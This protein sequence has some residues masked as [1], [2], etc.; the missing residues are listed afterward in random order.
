MNELFERNE[1]QRE[2]DRAKDESKA[3]CVTTAV[4]CDICR[5]ELADG[6]AYHELTV[7]MNDA[8]YYV[9]GRVGDESAVEDTSDLTVCSRCEPDVSAAVD[10]LLATLWGL[11]AKD[12]AVGETEDEEPTVRMAAELARSGLPWRPSAGCQRRRRNEVKRDRGP[13]MRAHCPGPISARHSLVHHRGHDG[14]SRPRGR[15]L[16]RGRAQPL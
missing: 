4:E 12:T 13:R 10:H 2:I 1:R 8:P 7:G 11:R 9:R 3:G 14:L 5:Q 15:S 6:E 16:R